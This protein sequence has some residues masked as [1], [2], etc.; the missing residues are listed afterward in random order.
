ME[1][2]LKFRFKKVIDEIEPII[3]EIMLANLGS[4]IQ[5]DKPI[6]E[7]FTVYI[8]EYQGARHELMHFRVYFWKKRGYWEYINNCSLKDWRDIIKPRLIKN[9]YL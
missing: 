1:K 7:R 9:G 8:A 2:G 4:D 5:F 6:Y 3:P